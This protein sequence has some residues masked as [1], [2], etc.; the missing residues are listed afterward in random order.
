MKNFIL[1]LLVFV[2][3]GGIGIF[4]LHKSGRLEKSTENISAHEINLTEHKADF[5]MPVDTDYDM[6]LS[7]YP[8]NSLLSN[9]MGNTVNS[10]K[11]QQGIETNIKSDVE[12]TEN[13]RPVQI[14][15]P[16][17]K[18][19]Q[20]II[21]QNLIDYS[22]KLEKAIMAGPEVKI[23]VIGHFNDANTSLDNYFEGL[24]RAKHIKQ[25]II[26]NYKIP[27]SYIS[28]ISEG[29]SRNIVDPDINYSPTK[30][31]RIEILIED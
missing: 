12:N 1:A 13:S 26:E 15:F 14:L 10:I 2:V 22:K 23:T 6:N 21:D 28:A 9:E 8:D 27:E 16:Q 17:F 4:Y 31:N 24:Q 19:G 29:E 20:L 7:I 3:W 5:N 18:Y 25:Y 11:E 30:N